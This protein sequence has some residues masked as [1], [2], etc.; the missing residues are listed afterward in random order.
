[1]RLSCGLSTCCAILCVIAISLDAYGEGQDD[2]FGITSHQGASPIILA[3][4]HGYI[5]SSIGQR[6]WDPQYHDEMDEYGTSQ[7]LFNLMDICPNC[8][9]SGGGG[10]GHE[11]TTDEILQVVQTIEE[12]LGAYA[13]YPTHDGSCWD[14]VERCDAGSSL[15]ERG[16]S[17]PD[18][19]GQEA[20]LSRIVTLTMVSVGNYESRD[21]G[22]SLPNGTM[23]FCPNCA[24]SGGGGSSSSHED[25]T[26]MILSIVRGIASRLAAQAIVGYRAIYCPGGVDFHVLP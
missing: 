14:S 24:G 6:Y 25:T 22:T 15:H 5:C 8:A 19:V 1:M 13:T 7:A 4:M 12:A 9:G 21:L 16:L 20:A 3:E 26:D 11:D 2:N 23:G 18:G 10:A 17:P